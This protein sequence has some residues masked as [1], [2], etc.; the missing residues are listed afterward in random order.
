M[1]ECRIRQ[2]L[3][4]PLEEICS[5][6][7]KAPTKQEQRT[8]SIQPGLQFGWC[9]CSRTCSTSSSWPTIGQGP[10]WVSSIAPVGSLKLLQCRCTGGEDICYYTCRQSNQPIT[11]QVLLDMGLIVQ[12][13]PWDSL[14]AA[15]HI[16]NVPLRKS[17]DKA[18]VLIK[19][20]KQHHRHK[21]TL[22]IF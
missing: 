9:C 21:A 10:W 3:Y 5:S 7:P 16:G 13:V 1:Y 2:K 18:L 22:R 19:I 6:A 17:P 20:G 12:N 14:N 8:R 15:L 4:F 11:L